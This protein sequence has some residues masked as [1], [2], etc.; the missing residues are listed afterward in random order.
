MPADK[1][2]YL[3]QNFVGP[4]LTV[5]FT[6][7]DSGQ[8]MDFKVPAGGEELKCIAPGRYTATVD[9]P[10]PWANVNFSFTAFAGEREY[11]PFHGR[12]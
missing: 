6:N 8:G 11:M 1:A 2:C 5:T 10:P 9:A 3:V 12:N 7:Q 4:E